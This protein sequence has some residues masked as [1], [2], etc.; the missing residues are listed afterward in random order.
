MK[1]SNISKVLSETFSETNQLKRVIVITGVVLVLSVLSF[2]GYYYWDRYVH[3]GDQTPIGK[4]I[5]ELEVAVTQSPD[6][7]D[8]RLG[9]SEAYMLEGRYD[10][11]IAQASQV[12]K[13]IPD[14]E[15]ALFVVGVSY[16]SQGKVERS[17]PPLEKFAEIRSK[18]PTANMDDALETALYYLGSGYN[19]QN[20]YLDAIQALARAI[21]INP[22]DA[23]AFYQLALANQK[24]GQYDQAIQYYQEAVRFVPDFAEAYQGLQNSYTALKK[25]DYAIYAH[26]MFAFSTKDYK[27]ARAELEKATASL[28]DFAPA[29]L[30]LGLTDEKLGDLQSAKTNLERA[31]QIDPGNFLATQALTRVQISLQK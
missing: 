5:Q 22:T 7:K 10:D 17:L 19:S 16:A 12:L 23:D 15:R 3:L 20:R 14:N 27:T 4:S 9:L 6:D 26:G 18:A 30:G 25:P 13:S 2:G 31:V 21:K 8:L 24:V 29:F 28:P 11:A 1:L